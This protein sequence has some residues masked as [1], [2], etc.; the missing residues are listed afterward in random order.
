MDQADADV[1]TDS[2]VVQRE[3]W[4]RKPARG[5]EG[6]VRYVNLLCRCFRQSCK[7]TP[8]GCMMHCC[9]TTMYQIWGAQQQPSQRAIATPALCAW[10]YHMG[11]YGSHLSLLKDHFAGGQFKA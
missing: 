1:C 6:Q 2:Q 5:M 8:T 11:G 4:L 9:L 7:L 10:Q 3:M